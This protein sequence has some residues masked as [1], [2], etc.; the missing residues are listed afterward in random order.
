M[1]SRKMNFQL[2]RFKL[3]TH[4]KIKPRGHSDILISG[5]EFSRNMHSHCAMKRNVNKILFP[6][7]LAFCKKSVE[8]L[9]ARRIF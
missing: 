3:T 2:L 5:I 1:H 7:L 9:A 8:G 4:N 6:G